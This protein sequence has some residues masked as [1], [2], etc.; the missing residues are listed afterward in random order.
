MFLQLNEILLTGSIDSMDPGG[1]AGIVIA[2]L[3]V[4]CAFVLLKCAYVVRQ[5]EG[6]YPPPQ[7]FGRNYVAH[8]FIVVR[9]C[10]R[11][12]WALSSGFKA[13]AVIYCT[14]Y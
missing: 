3:F 12:A 13:R 14:F 10:C 9:S 5:A 2:V 6:G 7:R 11:A 4:F 8:I 1:T